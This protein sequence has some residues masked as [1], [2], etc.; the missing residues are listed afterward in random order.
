MNPERQIALLFAYFTSVIVCAETV[1]LA[2][3]P[4]FRVST[5]VSLMLIL[6]RGAQ[7]DK[8]NRRRICHFDYSEKR[9]HPFDIKEASDWKR[10]VTR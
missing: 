7:E 6:H 4:C 1:H 3:R 10:H 5:P 2:C 8:Q 9:K